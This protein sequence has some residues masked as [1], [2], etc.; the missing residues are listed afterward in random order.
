MAQNALIKQNK[1]E[2]GYKALV[3]L[4]DVFH[5]VNLQELNSINEK[6]VSSYRN[7]KFAF[8]EI[9]REFEY[10]FSLLN[11]KKGIMAGVLMR[12]I[13]EDM[14]YFIATSI[15]PEISVSI[16]SP[17]DQ[18]RK[19]VRENFA[20]CFDDLFEVDDLRQ[21]YKH[22]CKIVHVTSI[23]ECINYLESSNKYCDYIIT[24]LK[25]EAIMLECIFLDYLHRQKKYNHDI[26]RETMGLEVAISIANCMYAIQENNNKPNSRISGFFRDEASRRYLQTNSD[27]VIEELASLSQQ[28]ELINSMIRN[29]SSELEKK[30]K[31]LGYEQQINDFL[32]FKVAK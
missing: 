25:C 7:S 27:V 9:K 30:Y 18:F 14:M 13:Y 31:D 17:A 15:N 19:Y 21:F 10:V 24:E 28:I 6:S 12:N 20:T 5:F 1:K 22:L 8:K 11:D 32:S 2:N 4:L 3:S 16:T 23:K 26:H 29:C